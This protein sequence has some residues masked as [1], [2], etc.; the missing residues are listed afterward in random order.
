M[1]KNICTADLADECQQQDGDAQFLHF[2]AGRMGDEFPACGN[3]NQVIRNA[4]WFL[5]VPAAVE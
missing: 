3:A 5:I 4:L 2:R 1:T